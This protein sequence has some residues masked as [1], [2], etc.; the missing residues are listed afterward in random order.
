MWLLVAAEEDGALPVGS[1]MLMIMLERQEA[2][3]SL[4]S[5]TQA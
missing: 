3:Q 4:I 5:I 1:A 2:Q